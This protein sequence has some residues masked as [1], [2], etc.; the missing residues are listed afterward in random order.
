[1]EDF[2]HKAKHFGLGLF[3]FTKEKVEALVDEM[4]KRGELT[5]QESSLAV[6]KIM[7]R[8]KAEQEALKDKLTVMIQQ[9]ISNMNL[10]R[11]ADLEALEKRVAALEQKTA[12]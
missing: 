6:A 8:A 10:A 3:D 2:W 11:A 1:M 7:E 12:R 4:V 9:A 5:Q